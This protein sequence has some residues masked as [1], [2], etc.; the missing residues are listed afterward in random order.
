MLNLLFSVNELLR[1]SSGMPKDLRI[2]EGKVRPY[3]S[4]AE[5]NQ[6]V[7]LNFFF[8]ITSQK[9]TFTLFSDIAYDS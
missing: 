2:D 7:N 5:I 9:L 3:L 1:F 6:F 8:S 4:V